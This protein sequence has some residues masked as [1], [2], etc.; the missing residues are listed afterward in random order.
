[1]LDRVTAAVVGTLDRLTVNPW[2]L[3]A[4]A[5][6]ANSVLMP[7]RGLHHDAVIYSG[8]VLHSHD[9]RLGQD[10]F[11]RYGSQNQYTLL[12][13]LLATPAKALGLEPIFFAAYLVCNLLRLAAS[14]WLILRVFGRTPASAAGV[15]LVAAAP[16][17]VG[18]AE[19]FSVNEPFFTARVPAF[20]LAILG[21]ERMLDR[22]W[23]G[24]GVCLAVASLVHPLVAFP[25]IAV[26]LGWV[27]WNWADSRR[28]WGMVAVAVGVVGVG[29]VG[30]LVRAVGSLD[31]EWRFLVLVLNSYLDPT[32]WALSDVIRLGIFGFSLVG[33]IRSTSDR[34]M[35]RFLWLV[36]A[37]AVVGYAVSAFAARGSWAILLQGQAY[38]AVWILE[39]LG[40]P[41]GMVAVARLWQA[42]PA[43]RWRAVALLAGILATRDLLVF[44]AWVWL[45]T[46]MVVAVAV[47]VAIG[48]SR[49]DPA[50][51]AWVLAVGLAIWA[52]GWYCVWLPIRFA[53]LFQAPVSTSVAW[54]D[55]FKPMLDA[56]GPVPMLGLALVGAGA[57]VRV[58]PARAAIGV[59]IVVGLSASAAE[60]WVPQ[61]AGYRRSVDPRIG[62]YAF[63]RSF[64]EEHWEEPRPAA[65]YW[66]FG[67]LSRIWAELGGTCFFN[68]QQLPGVTFSRPFAVESFRR[69]G[70][71]R[72]FEQ[73]EIGRQFGKQSHLFQA[74]D[75]ELVEPPTE[76]DFQ[77][78][79]AE[80]ELDFAVLGREFPGWVATNGRVWV[81][82]CRKLRAGK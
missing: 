64:L 43:D 6:A 23:I 32:R 29:G 69:F 17:S 2:L 76:E 73:D 78:L 44:P 65:I 52:I 18:C 39:L 77:K 33:W 68:N 1:M 59:S 13:W 79:V 51:A 27:V 63:V 48:K 38:R 54:A 81:Y 56:Y 47:G 10:P 42:E 66:S 45:L 25:A 41:A 26:A 7:Y 22:R 61:T 49:S 4:V 35:R 30:Y 58:L 50:W 55:R 12:P 16:V 20:A 37:A 19:I 36:V 46:A 8:Q 5:F 72:P 28:R 21:L 31:P 11:F 60:F 34:E 67:R 15:L 62:D 80:P 74:P 3:F 75:A 53:P 71:V 82:D 14:Q 40:Y 9:G 57:I 70:V 24:A